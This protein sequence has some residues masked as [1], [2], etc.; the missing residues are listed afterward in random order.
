MEL[1]LIGTYTAICVVIFK[2]FRI[3][4]NKW[5]VPTAFLGGVVMIGALLLVMNYNHLYS[6]VAREYYATTPI[7]PEVRGRVVEVPV[8]PNVPLK[9]GDVLFRID[10]ERFEYEVEGPEARLEAARKE[11]E[12]AEH[13]V[14][15]GAGIEREL[16][17]WKPNSRMHSSMSSR[18]RSGP[19]PTASSPN[20]HCARA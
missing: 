3:P 1:L 18:P 9:K 13:L 11:A 7:I 16:E 17:T 20:S 6:E 15:A 8:K 12:R 14:K 10:P 4:L 5:T 2:V 19:Q